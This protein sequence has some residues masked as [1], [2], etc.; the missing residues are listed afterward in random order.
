MLL[1]Q[2]TSSMSMITLN[3][4]RLLQVIIFRLT[5]FMSCLSYSSGYSLFIHFSITLPDL[6]LPSH[7]LIVLNRLRFLTSFWL[8]ASSLRSDGHLQSNRQFGEMMMS[9]ANF[10]SCLVCLCFHCI[11]GW[12]WIQNSLAC[13][14]CMLRLLQASATTV[15]CS[16]C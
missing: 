15:L 4:W 11:A 8:S 7:H 3:M 10:Y 13:G 1:E 9:D 6:S 14:S 5:R 2:V 12:S 16:C